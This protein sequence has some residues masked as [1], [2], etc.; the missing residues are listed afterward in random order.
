MSLLDT[1][2]GT[3]MNFAYGWALSHPVRKVYYNLTLT[4]L[5]IAVAFAVGSVELLSVAAGHLGLHG[6]FWT[7]VSGLNLNLLGY[8]IAGLFVLTWAVSIA[9]WRLGR[10]EERWAPRAHSA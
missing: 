6:G 5:S 2:D 8:L 7:W 10:I 4:G 3:F 9:V 1:I